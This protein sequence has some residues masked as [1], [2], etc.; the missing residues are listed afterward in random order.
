MPSI[1]QIQTTHLL[2]ALTESLSRFEMGVSVHNMK[3]RVLFDPHEVNRNLVVENLFGAERA[4]ESE[5][6]CG[7]IRASAAALCYLL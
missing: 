6:F 3:D 4:A 2:P 5:R 1:L 7:E